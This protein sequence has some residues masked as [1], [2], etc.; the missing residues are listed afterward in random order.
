MKRSALLLF[1]GGQEWGFQGPR[2]FINQPL[3]PLTQLKA[4]FCLD[5]RSGAKGEKE[6]CLAGSSLRPSLSQISKKFLEPLGLKEAKNMDLSSPELAKDRYPF[7]DKGIP[8]LDF[9]IGDPRRTRPSPHSQ[10]LI[11]Y[12]KLTN[13][14]KLI[15]LTAYEFLTEP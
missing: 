2:D 5:A 1:F 13:V 4:A 3:I 11:D 9:F 6:V 15:Y 7:R 10:E 8:S 14:T 12:E